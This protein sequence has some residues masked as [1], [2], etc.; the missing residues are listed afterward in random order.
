MAESLS[1]WLP[2]RTVCRSHHTSCKWKAMSDGQHLNRSSILLPLKQLPAELLHRLAQKQPY[3]GSRNAHLPSTAHWGNAMHMSC[4]VYAQPLIHSLHSRLGSCLLRCCA[5]R[6]GRPSHG[7]PPAWGRP[8]KA[9]W[10]AHWRA[11]A[12]WWPAEVGAWRRAKAWP[13]PVAHVWPLP[14]C[15]WPCASNWDFKHF[16]AN[17]R[18]ASTLICQRDRAHRPQPYLRHLNN[19]SWL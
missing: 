10:P 8:A 4:S 11:P 2:S 13:G 16:V 5:S 3:L 1:A 19:A 18:S 14:F 12:W 15:C 17:T 9:A 7:R 6:A